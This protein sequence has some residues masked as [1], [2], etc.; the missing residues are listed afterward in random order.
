MPKAIVNRWYDIEE[1]SDGLH[2]KEDDK[3]VATITGATPDAERLIK[4][5]RFMMD[6]LNNWVQCS[7]THDPTCICGRD[8]AVRAIKAGRGR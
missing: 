7:S 8:N 3:I 1:D 4:A 5:S 2:I 6:A